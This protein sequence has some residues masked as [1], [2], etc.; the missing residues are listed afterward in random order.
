MFDLP[1]LS[2]PFSCLGALDT[3]TTG[4][5]VSG[6]ILMIFGP[7]AEVADDIETEGPPLCIGQDFRRFRLFA[8]LLVVKGPSRQ[9]MASRSESAAEAIES[10]RY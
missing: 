8:E 10:G 7:E 6:G 5:E 3:W 2:M 9:S 4:F 1:P